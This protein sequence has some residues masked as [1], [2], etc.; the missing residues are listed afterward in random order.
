MADLPK[1]KWDIIRAT[2]WNN[3]EDGRCRRQAEFLVRDRFPL[4][5]VR[6]IGVMDESARKQ[7]AELLEQTSLQPLLQ[8]RREWYF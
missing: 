7:V 1:V 6:E 3:F 8:V 4:T 2:Y 5:L